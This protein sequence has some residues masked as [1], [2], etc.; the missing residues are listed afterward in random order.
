MTQWLTTLK[1]TKIIPSITIG[2]IEQARQ[3][4]Q[5]LVDSNI[6]VAEISFNHP[7]SSELFKT[8]K[9]EFP[10]MLLLAGGI[11]QLEKAALAIES[12]ADVL[13]TPSI[14]PAILQ[15]AK[16]QNCPIIPG[17]NTPLSLEIALANDIS[18]VKF[19]PAEAS[20]GAKLIKALSTV[21][22][23]ISY[24]PSGGIDDSNIDEYFAQKNVIACGIGFVSEAKQIQKGNW[25]LLK[26]RI[27]TIQSILK[28]R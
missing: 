18:V 6:L 27:K 16:S 3:M 21:Y 24:I 14:N 20:G 23:D 22:S 2:D 19:F 1:A 13:I 17:I 10:Q 28:Y 5:L 7:N 4:I 26:T 11:I 9:T 12:G 8:L 25:R 15:F